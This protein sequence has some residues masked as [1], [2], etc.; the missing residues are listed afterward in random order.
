MGRSVMRSFVATLLLVAS[1]C[2]AATPT[3][4][5]APT[6]RPP[7]AAIVAPDVGAPA[8]ATDAAS[9]GQGSN[10]QLPSAAPGTIPRTQLVTTLDGGLG[11]FLGTVRVAA[12]L[13][14]GSFVGFR[15]VSFRD[16]Q[17]IY[18]GVDL[19]P[20]DVV[21]RVNGSPIERPEQALAVW[22]GLRVTSELCVEYVRNGER[23]EIRF[24]I[25]D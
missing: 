8:V 24:P 3:R 20:G 10:P 13:E 12:V 17:G 22:N 21:L 23:R 4:S 14:R 6:R 19:T 25:V 1:G 7:A 11:R 2:A 9:G 5:T 18:A 16:P 15:I